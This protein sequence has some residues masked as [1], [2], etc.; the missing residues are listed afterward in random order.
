MSYRVTH[1]TGEMN[2]GYPIERF[3]DL[4]G[5][6]SVADSEHPDI[7]VVHESEWSLTVYRSGFVVL[8]NLE[9]GEPMHLGP[10]DRDRTI[11]LMIGVAE[12]RIAE[13]QS[14][15]WRPGYPPGQGS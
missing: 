1:C 15:P 13:L 14:E 10:L 3:A 11:E 2:P 6:L 9:D 12:G 5:E 7:A 8:E 4:L